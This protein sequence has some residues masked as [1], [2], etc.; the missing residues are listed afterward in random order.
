MN[1]RRQKIQIN[2]IESVVDKINKLVIYYADK[3]KQKH[4]VYST[5]YEFLYPID[6]LQDNSYVYKSAI[7]ELNQIDYE[8]EFYHANFDYV[9]NNSPFVEKA[10][11]MRT[12]IDAFVKLYYVEYLQIE[13]FIKKMLYSYPA[14]LEEK[15]FNNLNELYNKMRLEGVSNT[16]A[17]QDHFKI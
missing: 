1:P 6:L 8:R 15:D 17:M 12:V 9:Y 5:K 16:K 13:E 4:W 11:T 10:P 7:V 2:N 3:R 14:P